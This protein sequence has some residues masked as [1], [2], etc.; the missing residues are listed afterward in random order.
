MEKL[1][2]LAR[3]E[4]KP[5]KENEVLEFLKSALPLAEAEPGTVRW[6]ALKIGPSTF[7]IFDTFETDQ[8]RQAH[9]GG[10]IAAALMANA[11]TLLA[12]A[13]VIE[14]VELIA[15]K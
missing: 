12:T 6:Y 14:Q 4:A 3:V 9:L 5:G 2:L 8:A 10:E 7:G 11:S 13:P 1:A 15:V